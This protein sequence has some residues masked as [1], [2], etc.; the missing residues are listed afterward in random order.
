M[1]LP[2]PVSD[3]LSDACARIES[4]EKELKKQKNKKDSKEK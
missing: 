4:L 3:I 1:H 2:D